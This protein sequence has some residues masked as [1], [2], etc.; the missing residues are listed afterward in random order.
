MNLQM[1]CMKLYFFSSER[2][3]GAPAIIILDDELVTVATLLHE[4][5]GCSGASIFY[6]SYM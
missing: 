1:P 3:Y 6:Y 4:L 5:G 2:A